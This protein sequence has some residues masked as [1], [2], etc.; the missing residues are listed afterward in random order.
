MSDYVSLWL[1]VC[2]FVCL[3]LLLCVLLLQATTSR[4]TITNAQAPRELRVRSAPV[5]EGGIQGSN[6]SSGDMMTISSGTTWVVRVV[7]C[8]CVRSGSDNGRV[9]AT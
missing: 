1:C 6:D 9:V 3:L 5:G 4:T 7:T 8:S 2:A